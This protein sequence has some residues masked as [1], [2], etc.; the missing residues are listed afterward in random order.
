MRDFFRSLYTS[1]E[2]CIVRIL[3]SADYFNF[4]ILLRTIQGITVLRYVLGKNVCSNCMLLIEIAGEDIMYFLFI[5]H[6]F[7]VKWATI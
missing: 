4:W 3:H 5:Q 6:A 2:P 1:M 7:Q